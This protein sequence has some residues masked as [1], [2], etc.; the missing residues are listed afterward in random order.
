MFSTSSH[1]L[2]SC[3]FQFSTWMEHPNKTFKPSQTL[4]RIF[5]LILYCFLLLWW[6]FGTRLL[7]GWSYQ[8]VITPWSYIGYSVHSNQSNIISKLQNLP[9]INWFA[10]SFGFALGC[11]KVLERLPPLWWSAWTRKNWAALPMNCSTIGHS[12]EAFTCLLCRNIIIFL[13]SANTN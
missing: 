8:G 10:F 3:K 5:V 1:T 9:E 7:L 12:Y 11:L 4:G 2:T 13:L 6:M